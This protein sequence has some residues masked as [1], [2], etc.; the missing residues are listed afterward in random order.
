MKQGNKRWTLYWVGLLLPIWA[1]TGCRLLPDK[2]LSSPANQTIRE[3]FN[4]PP[5]MRAGSYPAA[6]VGTPWLGQD[7]GVH[8]YYYRPMERDGIAYACRGGHVDIAHLRIAT[9]W[10]AY[11]ATQTYRHLMKHDSGFSYKLAVD[12]SRDYIQFSYPPDWDSLPETQRSR[13]AQEMALAVGP[14]LTYKMTTWHEILTW[15]G[16]KCVGL[17]TEFPSAF[18]WEDSFSNLLGT[19][20]AVRALQDPEHPYEEAVKIALDEEMAKL[21]LQPASVSNRAS[22]SVKGTWSTGDFTMLLTIMKR[23]FDIGLG[24]GMVTPSL[25]PNV[26]ECP[27]AEPLSYPAPNLDVLAKHG[28]SMI[29]EIE[30]REW[31]SGKI[32]AV[33]Y[34]SDKPG[35]RID[36][37]R[38]FPIIMDYIR[39]ATTALYPEFD[40]TAY[41]DGSPPNTS[42]AK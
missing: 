22:E 12:R 4:R 39:K 14:Y 3:G 11:L 32:L 6:I 18:S 28:F 36:P 41:E 7:L 40:Y 13:T 27:S 25:V 29:L 38:H 16:F 2:G 30:P 34:G 1:A 19:V 35:K 31:E 17:P 10:T 21:G 26:P 15:F 37:E 9:D 24:D 23:N 5:R 33:A 20:V 42:L 8:G